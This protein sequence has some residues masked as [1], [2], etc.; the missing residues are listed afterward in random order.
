ME[1][2]TA[3]VKDGH[4]LNGLDIIFFGRE[5]IP[6]TKPQPRNPRKR[7]LVAIQEQL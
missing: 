1:I 3:I 2:P 5:S 4:E 6:L 7:R